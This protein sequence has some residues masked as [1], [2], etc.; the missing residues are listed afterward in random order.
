MKSLFTKAGALFYGMLV[1]IN[2]SLAQIT[3]NSGDLPQAGTTYTIQE[4][5]PDPLADY[6]AT[7]AGVVWDFSG[8]DSNMEIEITYS[9]IDNAPTLTQLVF[10]NTWTSPDH[11][12]DVFAPGDLPDFSEAGIELPIEIGSLNNY[13]QSSGGSFNIAGFSMGV[14]GVDMPITYTDIDEIH[15]IPLNYGDQVNSTSAYTVTIP[16]AFSY[17]SIGTRTGEVDGWGTLMLPNGSEHEV[18]RLTTVIEKSDEFT[19]E[20]MEAIPFEYETTVHQWL[21]DGGVPYLEVHST[22]GAVFRV[23]YK[24]SAVKDTSSTE[25]INDVY[26]EDIKLFP[27]PASE[28]STINLQGFDSNSVWEVRNSAGNICL[29]GTGPTLNSETLSSGTY[30]LIERPNGKGLVY[31]PTIFIVQ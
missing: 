20:G 26:T 15:P 19:P 16:T 29:E 21:G 18:I 13:Y 8:L 5:T 31:R 22:F 27:N 23:R 17:S 25:G 10:N 28:G 6:S 11:V 9:D 3:V 4:S 14:Q 30:F 12:C 7:G 1:F 24:G 2:V